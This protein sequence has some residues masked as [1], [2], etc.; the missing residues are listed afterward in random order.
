MNKIIEQK[1]KEFKEKWD[2]NSELET[3]G[4]FNPLMNKNSPIRLWQFIETALK[5]NTEA[6]CKDMIVEER[7]GIYAHGTE[8]KEWWKAAGDRKIGFNQCCVI[9]KEN[10]KKIK[11]GLQ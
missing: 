6:T 10:E 9:G 7:E 1:K 4:F 3:G 8:S 2:K 11:K 5:E